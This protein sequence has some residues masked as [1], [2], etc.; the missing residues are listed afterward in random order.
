M[1]DACIVQHFKLSLNCHSMSLMQKKFVRS[2]YVATTDAVGAHVRN[3]TAH[4]DD[5]E[6]LDV[7]AS[8][9]FRELYEDIDEMLNVTYPRDKMAGDNPV[10]VGDSCVSHFHWDIDCRTTCRRNRDCPFVQIVTFKDDQ[11]D[12]FVEIL[13]DSVAHWET[14][15]FLF[16]GDT[17]NSDIVLGNRLTDRLKILMTNQYPNHGLD[18]SDILISTDRDLHV[19]YT[20]E[21]TMQTIDMQTYKYEMLQPTFKRTLQVHLQ[22]DQEYMS[23]TISVMFDTQQHADAYADYESYLDLLPQIKEIIASVHPGWSYCASRPITSSIDVCTMGSKVDAR[24]PAIRTLQPTYTRVICFTTTYEDNVTHSHTIAVYFDSPQHFD[25]VEKNDF[26]VI[27]AEATIMVKLRYPCKEVHVGRLYAASGSL[28]SFGRV[29]DAR[30]PT[31]YIFQPTIH[32]VLKVIASEGELGLETYYLKV[33]FDSSE[34]LDICAAYR[35]QDITNDI[36]DAVCRSHNEQY[37]ASVN[38]EYDVL[39]SF[40]RIV[41]A[42]TLAYASDAPTYQKVLTYEDRQLNILTLFDSLKHY[43]YLASLHFK[44][45]QINIYRFSNLN[46]PPFKPFT[47]R[48]LGV[49]RNVFAVLDVRTPT[50]NIVQP[51]EKCMYQVS[52]YDLNTGEYASHQMWFLFDSAINSNAYAPEN[53][54]YSMIKDKFPSSTLEEL[55]KT[56]RA[57]YPTCI[58]RDDPKYRRYECKNAVCPVEAYVKPSVD[59]GHMVDLRTPASCDMQHTYP[60]LLTVAVPVDPNGEQQDPSLYGVMAYF[61]DE[62]HLLTY[63]DACFVPILSKIHRIIWPDDDDMVDIGDMKVELA[64]ADNVQFLKHS[65]PVAPKVLDMRNHCISMPDDA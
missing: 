21:A 10:T 13:F 35:F 65:C 58:I 60:A 59:F 45:L 50:P 3:V 44:P 20:E 46:V 54:A 14:C 4:F 11:Q 7:H 40:P 24:T 64:S 47:V 2:L 55:A 12:V 8:C 34:H 37:I 43:E 15:S 27:I 31:P 49:K 57:R 18:F 33:L 16:D 29:I 56:V 5:Q 61:D 53:L 17:T 1:L 52:T 36:Y 19:L 23:P 28:P 48:S 38:I 51:T 41:D 25:F 32:T 62:S 9:Q 22:K 63:E 6:H 30:T 26:S 42:R 39:A